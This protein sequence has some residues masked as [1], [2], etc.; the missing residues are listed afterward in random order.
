[1]AV[2][3]TV[4]AWSWSWRSILI[5]YICILSCST[6]PWLSDTYI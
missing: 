5:T 2:G 1:V 4:L 6:R 3:A